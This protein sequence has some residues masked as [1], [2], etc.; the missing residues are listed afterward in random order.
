MQLSAKAQHV[1]VIVLDVDGVLTDGSFGYDS[2]GNE[3]K[4]FNVRDGHG[5]K[6]ARRAGLKVGLLS[7]RSSAANL[8]RAQ[9][10]ELD[11]VYQGEKNKAE[12]FAR[13]LT[14][15]QIQPQHCLY[16]GDD[17]IDV[18]VMRQVGV[19]VAVADGVEQAHH[20]AD[21]ITRNN[22]GHGAVRE[23]IEWLLKQQGAWDAQVARYVE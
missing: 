3:I 21:W 14:E 11:F 9:E 16:V 22:G 10:L 8:H 20:V 18:P 2:A 5:I 13:L 4:F 7:G 19:A 1:R 15:L 12:A 6:L 23:V 17:L